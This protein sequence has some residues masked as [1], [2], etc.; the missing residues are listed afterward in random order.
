MPS[1]APVGRGAPGCGQRRRAG[2][3]YMLCL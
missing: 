1:G 3:R 2:A